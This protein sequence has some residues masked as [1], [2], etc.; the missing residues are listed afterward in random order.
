MIFLENLA[1]DPPPWKNSCTLFLHGKQCYC[2]RLFLTDLGQIVMLNYD[3]V[4]ML[5]VQ[6]QLFINPSRFKNHHHGRGGSDII[7]PVIN[8][9]QYWLFLKS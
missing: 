4:V 8:F 3:L 7:Y 9:N 2:L 1:L 5:D 6:C